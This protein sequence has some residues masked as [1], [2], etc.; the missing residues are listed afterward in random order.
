MEDTLLKYSG[1][2]WENKRRKGSSKN[3]ELSVVF[4]KSCKG[5]PKNKTGLFFF[6]LEENRGKG[7]HPAQP[8]P[9]NCMGQAGGLC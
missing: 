9:S 3:P 5:D 6:C 7:N 8:Q 1:S 2:I 4:C